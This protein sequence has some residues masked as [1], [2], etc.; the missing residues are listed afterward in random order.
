LG[1]CI[2]IISEIVTLFSEKTE[3]RG[4]GTTSLKIGI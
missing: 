4:N 1:F 2:E 3:A